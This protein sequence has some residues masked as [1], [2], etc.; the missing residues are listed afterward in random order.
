LYYD[1]LYE[2]TNKELLREGRWEPIEPDPAWDGNT[3]NE[4]ILAWLWSYND[5]RMLVIINYSKEPSQCSLNFD[6][7]QIEEMIELHDV[8][9]DVKYSRSVQEI[10]NIGLYVELQP[11]KSHIFVY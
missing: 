7:K 3:T 4:N 10:N 6:T 9:N 2:I 1:K 11:Y 5:E 8:L